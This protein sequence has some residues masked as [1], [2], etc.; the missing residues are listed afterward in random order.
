MVRSYFQNCL[1][2]GFE[3]VLVLLVVKENNINDDGVDKS[4]IQNVVN[5]SQEQ[6]VV[7]ESKILL[8]VDS[9]NSNNIKVNSSNN[10]NSSLTKTGEKAQ[11]S[12]INNLSN[13]FT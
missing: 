13:F 8:N 12:F 9:G 6:A 4:N 7:N 5:P 3:E 1:T 11:K 10:Q 2:V